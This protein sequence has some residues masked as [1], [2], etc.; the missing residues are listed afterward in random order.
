MTSMVAV[1]LLLAGCGASSQQS[2][3][4]SPGADTATEATTEAAVAEVEDIG[5]GEMFYEYEDATSPE[6]VNGKKIMQDAELLEF[7][8]ADVNEGLALPYDIPLIGMQCDDANAFWSPSEQTMTICYEDVDLAQKIFIE[9]GDADPIDSALNTEVATFYHELG[10]MAVDIYDLPS[11]GRQEDV[12]DQLAAFILLQ[13][14]DNG[15]LDPE[16]V[17]TLIDFSRE[18]DGYAAMDDGQIYEE[19]LADVHSLNQ[20]RSYNL[21][22]WAYGAD[23]E[24]NAAIVDD[25]RLPEA[26]AEV[27]EDEYSQLDHAWFTLLEPYLK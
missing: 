18:F 23:P 4:S 3:S 6:A 2:S 7:L 9:D 15:Q 14:D 27:C 21:L 8:V 12:A 19:Y 25:G 20:T 22:C 24:G 26:R 13:P 10:H 16:S 17:K 11:T 1:A 5:A